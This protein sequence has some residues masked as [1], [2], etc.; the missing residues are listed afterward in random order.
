MKKITLAVA[1]GLL[2]LT[3]FSGAYA[4]TPT[5]SQLQILP[6]ATNKFKIGGITGTQQTLKL[7]V[8]ALY[9][10]N[11]GTTQNCEKLANVPANEVDLNWAWTMPHLD[12]F[13]T[14][15]KNKDVIYITSNTG[16]KTSLLDNQKNTLKL[17][18][19]SIDPSD[20]RV[21]LYNIPLTYKTG[22]KI[23]SGT[24]KGGTYTDIA[25]IYINAVNTNASSRGKDIDVSPF[26]TAY[27]R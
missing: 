2:I 25:D 22:L 20:P 4:E 27:N 6:Q 7:R 14:F 26:I 19:P 8:M 21:C 15:E 3:T 16:T 11:V 17:Q 24:H 18:E 13:N 5:I 9:N 1:T 10:G 23:G 12:V